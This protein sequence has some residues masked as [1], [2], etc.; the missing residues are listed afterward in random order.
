M[1]KIWEIN[2]STW[3]SPDVSI[4]VM[5]FD[6]FTIPL[7]EVLKKWKNLNE[8]VAEMASDISDSFFVYVNDKPVTQENAKDIQLSSVRKLVISTEEPIKVKTLHDKM[9]E[10]D[11]KKEEVPGTKNNREKSLKTHS[12]AG[13]VGSHKKT[14]VYRNPDTQKAH[15]E[16][17]KK[18]E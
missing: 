6:V 14:D 4:S 2:K 12:H 11:A 13:I 9:E 7:T 10:D 3:K 8:I 17:M 15:D 5:E 18:E 1:A 16:E